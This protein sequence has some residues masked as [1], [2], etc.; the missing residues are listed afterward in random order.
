[1]QYADFFKIII[2]PILLTTISTL[3]ISGIITVYMD[4]S[5]LRLVIILCTTTIIF[6]ISCWGFVFSSKERKIILSASMSLLKEI[7]VKLHLNKNS[8]QK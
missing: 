3:S 7:K 4:E 6:I 1:M 8:Y 2:Y 5:F